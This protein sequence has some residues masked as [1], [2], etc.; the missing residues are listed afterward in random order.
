MWRIY[1][2][3]GSTWDHTQGLEGL[4][5]Y[6]VICI[7][8]ST[9]HKENTKY[10]VSHGAPYY[11]RYGGEWLHFYNNDMV[12]YITHG[13]HIEYLLVG[14]MVS[15]QVFAEIYEKAKQDRDLENL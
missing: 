12:D 6:G 1:Y 2:A 3:D 15:K 11:A 10:F 8:Q 7:L 14:R 13:I 9:K 4:E 5:P